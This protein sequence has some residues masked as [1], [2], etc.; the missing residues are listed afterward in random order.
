MERVSTFSKRLRQLLDYKHLRQSELARLSGVSEASISCYLSGKW[1]A[2]QDAVYA[3]SKACNVDVA[4]L[5]GADVPMHPKKKQDGKSGKE[6][7]D[8]H[9]QLIETV[10]GLTENEARLV[11]SAVLGILKDRNRTD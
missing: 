4:W 7:T 5:M 11:L 8:S 9:R 2:R 1:E 6:L 10:E 3:I